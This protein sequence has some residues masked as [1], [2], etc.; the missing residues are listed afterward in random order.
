[1]SFRSF[2]KLR[3]SAFGKQESTVIKVLS[4]W[5]NVSI[6]WIEKKKLE[7]KDMPTLSMFT[8]LSSEYLSLIH[9]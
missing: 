1:M 6:F 4:C 5:E 3:N 8:Y 9:I 7:E 2:R